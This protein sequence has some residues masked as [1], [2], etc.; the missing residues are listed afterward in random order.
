[1]NILGKFLLKIVTLDRGVEMARNNLTLTLSDM[2]FL[3]KCPATK[4]T[5]PL[6]E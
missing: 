3:E 5:L 6:E 4:N 1:M 2:G